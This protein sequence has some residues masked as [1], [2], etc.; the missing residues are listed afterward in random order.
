MDG[1][2][3]AGGRA[4]ASIGAACAGIAAGAVGGLLL[5]VVPGSTAPA[6]VFIVLAALGGLS[7]AAGGRS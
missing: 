1:R 7:G 2:G 4:G 5:A 6:D 3:A